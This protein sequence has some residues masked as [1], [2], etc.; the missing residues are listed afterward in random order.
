MT[1]TE[2]TVLEQIAE[3]RRSV[4]ALRAE[5]AA[6]KQRQVQQVAASDDLVQL[7]RLAVEEDRLREQ[8]AAVQAGIVQEQV[9]PTPIG[10]EAP[11]PESDADEVGDEV[12]TPE[13]VENSDE[14]ST[15]SPPPTGRS[16]SGFGSGN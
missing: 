4:E 9:V 2:A 8:L 14:S 6:S 1:E 11:V 7:D 15:T 10:D 5:I 12:P 13:P 3:K 16:F